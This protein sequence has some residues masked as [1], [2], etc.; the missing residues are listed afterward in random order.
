MAN[1]DNFPSLDSFL[2]STLGQNESQ[3]NKDADEY[4]DK[5]AMENLNKMK[6]KK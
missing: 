6:D 3:F 1:A 4:L 2:N 5:I